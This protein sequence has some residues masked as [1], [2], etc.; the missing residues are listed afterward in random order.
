VQAE[1]RALAVIAGLEVAGAYTDAI[2]ALGPLERR[3]EALGHAPLLAE[4]LYQRARLE[5]YR[6]DPSRARETLLRA[7]DL[8]ESQRHDRVAAD[9]WG[10]LV[11]VGALPPPWPSRRRWRAGTGA[12]V[13]RRRACAATSSVATI[14]ARFLDEHDW[15]PWRTPR[16]NDPQQVH[17]ALMRG[18][19]LLNA[20]DATAAARSFADGLADAGACTR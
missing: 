14:W 1:R 10:F 11:E 8:A 5:H 15:T 4:L 16:D 17:P 19:V 20:G 3:V 6:G 7:V 18:L 9:A 12:R 13:R 2:T